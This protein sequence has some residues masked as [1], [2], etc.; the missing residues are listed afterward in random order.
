[1]KCREKFVSLGEQISKRNGRVSSLNPKTVCIY[2][3]YITKKTH[4]LSFRNDKFKSFSIKK[5]YVL[6]KL[7]AHIIP[8]KL[9]NKLD[10]ANNTITIPYIFFFELYQVKRFKHS[11]QVSQTTTSSPHET[12]PISSDFDGIRGTIRPSRHAQGDLTENT[13]ICSQVHA[14]A[15]ARVPFEELHQTEPI[16]QVFPQPG[17]S[18]DPAQPFPVGLFG[19]RMHQLPDRDGRRTAATLPGRLREVLEEDL[20]RVQREQRAGYDDM[21]VQ[22]SADR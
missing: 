2:Y 5:L 19:C 13:I 18:G 11:R 10:L 3:V 12:A 20:R 1:M 9:T 14:Y 15:A 8:F 6:A 21:A 4:V 22:G 7:Q 16:H 17:K